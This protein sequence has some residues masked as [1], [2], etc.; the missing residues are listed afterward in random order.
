MDHRELNKSWRRRQRDVQ[1]EGNR[2]VGF[3]MH[4]PNA[5]HN[6]HKLK[7]PLLVVGRVERNTSTVHGEREEKRDLELEP[8]FC[9]CATGQP[10]RPM[11]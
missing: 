4:N 9:P 3:F 6:N 1:G 10:D 11:S 5:P 8:E 2:G 7:Y